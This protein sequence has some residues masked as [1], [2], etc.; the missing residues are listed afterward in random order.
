MRKLVSRIWG[1]LATPRGAADGPHQMPAST[2]RGPVLW[3]ILCGGLLVAAIIVGTAIMVGEFR[4]RALANS[5]RE[6]ENTVLLLTRHFDQQFE[7]SE[8]IANDLIAK[9]RLFRDRLGRGFQGPDVERRRAPDAEVQG[10]RACP[11]SATSRSSTPTDRLIN[12]SRRLAGAGHQHLRSRL[13]QDL[14]VRSAIAAGP[15]RAGAE[16]FHRQLDHR[17]RPSAERAGTATSS[18]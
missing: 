6:L 13:F 4:E 3:L 16:P 17:H 18:A 8:I 1:A 7:D 12:W 15:G 5:E 2:W 10:Q 9:M 11:I 14:Q